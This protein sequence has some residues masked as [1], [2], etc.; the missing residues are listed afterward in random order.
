MIKRIRS[1][2]MASL[3]QALT[4]DEIKMLT[5]SGV[6]KAYNDLS[7]DYNNIERAV[8]AQYGRKE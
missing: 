5:L 6:K 2:E 3:R 4:E 7:R 8:L 1:D